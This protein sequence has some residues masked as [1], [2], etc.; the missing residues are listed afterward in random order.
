MLMA[1]ILR[2]DYIQLTTTFMGDL[3]MGREKGLRNVPP[4]TARNKSYLQLHAPPQ[5][6]IHSLFI[7]SYGIHESFISQGIFYVH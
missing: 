6:T 5:T 4:E 7:S 3:P 2:N 1:K